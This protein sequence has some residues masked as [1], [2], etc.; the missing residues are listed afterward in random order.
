MAQ[1]RVISLVVVTLVA[2][3][4]LPAGAGEPDWAERLRSE[5]AALGSAAGFGAEDGTARLRARLASVDGLIALAEA[6]AHAA[7][8]DVLGEDAADMLASWSG[9]PLPV[10]FAVVSEAVA[11]GGVNPADAAEA[12]AAWL[13]VSTAAEDLHAARL[14]LRTA[15]GGDG[16]TCPVDGDY[17]YEN[18]WGEI[19]PWGRSHKGTDLLGDLGTPLVAAEAGTILQAD[20]HWAGGRQIY[21]RGAT[22]GD[23]YYY[24]HLDG[25]APEVVTGLRVAAGDFL[26]WMGASGNADDPHLHLGWMPRGGGLDNLQNP[27]RL[28]STICGPSR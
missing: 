3:G 1:H 2:L 7:A 26:G 10:A 5:Q 11:V 24:A 17:H 19:R 18:D 27:V 13:E 4:S 28:V 6:G 9:A 14:R 22:T 12:V 20:W 25:W 16:R 23:V 15:V 8:A 21:L